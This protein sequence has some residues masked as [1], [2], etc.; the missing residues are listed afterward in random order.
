METATKKYELAYFNDINKLI[1]LALPY[2]PNL[3]KFVS[4]ALCISCD[5]AN[6]VRLT[7][8]MYDA[9]YEYLKCQ[10]CGYEILLDVIDR[11]W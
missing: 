4:F 7:R 1:K 8:T 2:K 3:P 9:W 10:D 5:S 6:L 11:D